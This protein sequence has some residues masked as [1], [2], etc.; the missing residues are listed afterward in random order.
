[1]KKLVFFMTTVMLFT[2]CFTSR[3]I[4]KPTNMNTE[5]WNSISVNS[6]PWEESGAVIDQMA[7]L[8]SWDLLAT[9][10]TTKWVIQIKLFPQAAPKTVKNFEGLIS[11][12]FY[13]WLIFHRVI[14]DFMIQSWDPTWTWMWWESIYWG[15]FEDEPN[16]NLK[17]IRWALSMANKWPNTN[18]SQFFIVQWSSFSYL[19]W[20][21]EWK[22]I[23]WEVWKSCHTVFGQVVQGLEVVDQIA[24]VDVVDS[25]PKEEIKI[26]SAKVTTY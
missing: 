5:S 26:L 10:E 18:S 13:N 3:E 23:C 12:W 15:Y 7:W 14:K 19:D 16:P 24:S 21:Q 6:E 11:K 2:S 1:M 20:Y 22:N 17:N 9:I 4:D 8:K 25:R